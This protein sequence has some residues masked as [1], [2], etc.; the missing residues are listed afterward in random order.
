MTGF[1]DAAEEGGNDFKMYLIATEDDANIE[2]TEIKSVHFVSG[3]DVLPNS[4]EFQ[5]YIISGALL[6]P[7]LSPTYESADL[8]ITPRDIKIAVDA[9]SEE[10]PNNTSKT[11]GDE[12]PEEIKFSITDDG[13][14][15]FGDQFTGK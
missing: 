2:L 4:S 7:N 5:Q 14:L 13:Y 12:D 6:D 9:N 11:Y 3:L 10:Y 8:T 15:L 1:V